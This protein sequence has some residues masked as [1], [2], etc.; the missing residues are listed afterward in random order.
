MINKNTKV[1][2]E[3]TMSFVKQVN[4]VMYPSDRQDFFYALSS[5]ETSSDLN[6]PD[7]SEINLRRQ[8]VHNQPPNRGYTGYFQTGESALY[9]A[10]FF[11]IPYKFSTDKNSPFQ[12]AITNND[13]VGSWTGK[14]GV[15]SK[16]DYLRGR[17]H[18]LTAINILVNKNCG[19]IRNNN[20]NEFYGKIM[21]GIELTES[22]CIAA[23]HLVGYGSLR[24]YALSNGKTNTK[25]GNGTS[26]QDY[27]DLLNYY[28][29]ESCCNRKIYITVKDNN[30]PVSGTAVQVESEYKAGKHYSK[31]GKI[32]NTYTTNKEG[33]ILVIIRHPGAEIKITVNGKSQTIV[34]KADQRQSYT[35]DITGSI[36]TTGVLNKPSALTPRPVP[37]KSPQDLRNEQNKEQ[38]PS[39]SE[40]SKDITFNL[41][42]VEGDTKK[43]ITNMRYYLTYKGQSKE[44][45]TD[46]QG[47]ESNI[48]AEVGQDI[49]VCV[50]GEGRLQAV[51]HFKVDS[52]HQ[53]KTIR[54]LLPVQ[55]FNIEIKD[56]NKLPVKNTKFMIF[57]RGREIVKQTNSQG[58]ISV[59]MLVGFVY[60]FGLADGNPLVSLRCLKGVTHRTININETAKNKA[61]GVIDTKLSPSTNNNASSSPQPASKP[62]PTK[63]TVAKPKTTK[64][65]R[66]KGT[67]EQS[68]TEKNGRPITT[69]STDKAASD[70]TRY[71]IYHNGE[72]KRQNADATG[73]AEFIYY[74]EKGGK[75]NLGKSAY[76][77]GQRWKSKGNKDGDNKVY[78]IDIRKFLSYSK[79][80]VKYKMVKNSEGNFRYF[81]SGLAL[82]AYLGTLCKLG[83]NDISFN[84]FSTSNGDPGES[85]SHINGLVGDMRYL[86]KDFKAIA[87]T[88]FQNDYSH[89]RSLKLVKTLYDFGFGRTRNMYTERYSKPELN[90]KDYVLPHCEHYRKGTVRHHHHLHIQ[91][92]KPNLEDI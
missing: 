37:D 77:P 67:K 1:A 46:N 58:L 34:Q 39:S 18:Q 87:V 40:A 81:L 13:W 75:H 9:D 69:I 17:R 68:H 72:I 42:I 45:R 6:Q 82:A 90:L 12:K 84:G 8:N 49:E 78:L 86:R 16:A 80:K 14:D 79:D 71:H 30:S 41:T 35:I 10:G 32:K 66:N 33:K 47:I 54:A 38:Q 28:D 29:L 65:Q 11:T 64:E 88:V 20:I 24:D 7:N 21:N 61:T 74:D 52:S 59:K 51:A 55:A 48:T 26:V 3:A 83:Y 23:S 63:P 85:S 50:A 44:H 4:K 5:R 56:H 43:P 15:N 89:E 73:Y 70:T 57:Y 62:P 92:F 53:G 19:Y 76:K 36:K 25:N 2:K 60:K 27:M 31:V 91:G 22:G